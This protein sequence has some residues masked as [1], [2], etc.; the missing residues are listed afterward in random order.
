MERAWIGLGSNL[1]DRVE[2]LRSALAA[3]D[4]SV[5]VRV[6]ARSRLYET[7]PVGPPPQGPYLN[8]AAE[9]VVDLEPGALLERL[10]S[11]EALAGRDRSGLRWSARTLDLDL[12]LFGDRAERR[13]EQPDLIVPHP[14]LHERAFV[15]IPL[16]DVAADLRHPILGSTIRELAQAVAD[17]PGIRHY[18]EEDQ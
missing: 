13:V 11:I 10:H 3:L 6:I 1:G 2:H 4:D 15:L 18:A 5:G 12:L 17:Q 7:D 8:A 14:R 9:L 16:A